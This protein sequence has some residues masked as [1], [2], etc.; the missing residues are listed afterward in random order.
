MTSRRNMIKTLGFGAGLLV[1]SGVKSQPSKQESQF[2]YCLNPSTIRGQK[3]GIIRDIEIAARAGYDG[4]ELW[5]NDIM[6]Y[7]QEGKTIPSL[8]K[9]LQDSNLKFEN[10]I[11]F[12]TWM[13]DDDIQ[14][15]AGFDQM[16]KEMDMLAD[17]GCTRVAAPASGVNATLDLLLVGQRYKELIE[18]GRSTG[19]MPQ[20][21][22]WGAFPHF[23]HLGQALMV[24][25]ASNDPDAR[26]LA[27]VYHLFRGNSG[28]NGLKMLDGRLIEVFHMN[29]FSPDV[30]REKQQ[31][32]DRVYPGDGG[33]PMRQILTDLKNMGGEKVLS[34]ELFNRGYW[35][36]D[37]L[38]VAK[39]GLEKMKAAVA[40]IG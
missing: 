2:K 29:D 38:E 18:L 1:S 32:Q 4:V 31:D 25:A 36:Q 23:Y 13:V 14:R 10:A 9:H 35:N 22:F 24:V 33:A 6:A 40:S 28:Y 27:D 16:R 30:P 26:I 34:L 12:A 3:L 11:G 19:V 37:P 20:L 8:R 39:H 5:V 21:E 15:K 7:L 17:L